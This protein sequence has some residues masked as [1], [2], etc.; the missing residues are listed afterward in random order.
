MLFYNDVRN[1]VVH[2]VSTRKTHGENERWAFRDKVELILVKTTLIISIN[3]C[4]YMEQLNA[5]IF[6]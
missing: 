5:I 2:L 4:Y 1:S 6:Q 3:A